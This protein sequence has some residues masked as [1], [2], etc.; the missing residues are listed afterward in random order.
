MYDDRKY[1]SNKHSVFDLSSVFIGDLIIIRKKKEI[2]A[3]IRHR[4]LNVGCLFSPQSMVQ[5]YILRQGGS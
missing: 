4:Y 3:V 2:Q 1:N 5:I